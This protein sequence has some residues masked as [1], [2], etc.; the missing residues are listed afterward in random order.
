MNTDRSRSPGVPGRVQCPL[1]T[2]LQD[3]DMENC[4]ADLKTHTAPDGRPCPYQSPGNP[5]RVG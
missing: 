2:C 5:L 4:L 1:G 3:F